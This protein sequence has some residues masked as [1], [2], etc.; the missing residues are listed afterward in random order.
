[1]NSIQPV[2]AYMGNK[3]DIAEW[4]IPLFP[5]HRIYVE[6]FG[7]T[8]AILLNKLP[9]KSEF[10]NDYNQHLVNLFETTR[11]RKDEFFEQ[12]KQLPISEHLYKTFYDNHSDYTQ[13]PSVENAVRYLYIMSLCFMG[14]YDGGFKYDDGESFKYTFEKK[15]Q[16]LEVIHKR[17]KGVVMLNKNYDKVVTQFG[18]REDVLMYLDPPYVNTEGYYKHLAGE[19]TVTDHIKLRDLLR[20]VKCKFFLSYEDDPMVNDLYGQFFYIWRKN[21]VRRGQLTQG[22]KGFAE[23]VIVTNYKEPSSL[24]TYEQLEET[25]KVTDDTSDTDSACEE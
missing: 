24:F 3:V 21:K 2:F 25:K 17:M 13:F 1:M 6:V 4:I 5:P 23:E 18:K 19:F 8:G 20:K 14:K 15:M 12:L 10:Y 22:G 9:S 16:L 11:I 7:G